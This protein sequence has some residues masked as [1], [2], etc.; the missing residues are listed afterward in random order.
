[1]LNRKLKK[2]GGVI[3]YNER[4]W[5]EGNEKVKKKEVVVIPCHERVWAEVY[6]L[7]TMIFLKLK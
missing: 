5:A 2:G 7:R 3:P 6:I 4:L 1:M